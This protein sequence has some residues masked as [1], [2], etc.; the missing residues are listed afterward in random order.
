MK[1]ILSSALTVLLLIACLSIPAFADA[2]LSH[3][4]DEAGIL[5]DYDAAALEERAAEVS[6]QYGCGVYIVTVEDFTDYSDEYYIDGFGKELFAGYE[7]GLGDDGCG[8]LL[9]LSMAERDYALVAHGDFA[10]MAF[11]DYGK[12]VLAE[13]FLDDF[14]NDDWY[15]G[16]ADYIDSCAEFM[17]LA[18]DGQPVD[19]Q[20]SPSDENY[21]GDYGYD[22][23]GYDD[24]D[25]NFGFFWRLT[26]MVGPVT[27]L[28][29]IGVPAL[30]AL[31]VCLCMKRGMKTAVSSGN[32][33][34]YISP[35]GIRLTRKNDIYTHTTVTRTQNVPDDDNRGGGTTV[36]SGG[37][38][39]S[40][41][42]F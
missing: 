38:S 28:I 1:K 26:H 8:I 34:T 21:G 22:D 10:N 27:W 5:Y 42:K 41:G 3:V 25:F 11:T 17:R 19:V 35:E 32:A 12:E 15:Q 20:D 18:A 40:R 16:F 30:I 37:F 9:I 6:G 29:I 33:N 4:T 13:S 14:R 39:S 7:L 23:Y 31:T 36:D 2:Q 24:S